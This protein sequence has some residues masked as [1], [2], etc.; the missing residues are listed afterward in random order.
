VILCRLAPYSAVTVFILLNFVL[1]LLDTYIWYLLFS[2]A[3]GAYHG[4]IHGISAWRPWS[5]DILKLP[6][7]LYRKLVPSVVT[8]RQISVAAIWNA[9]V[10]SFFRDH[11][12]S[13]KAVQQML[14]LPG[15]GG[16]LNLPAYLSA[17]GQAELSEQPLLH[18]EAWRRIQFLSKSL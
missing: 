10:L 7:Q 4:L 18:Q 2:T 6:E 9:I 5:S 11:L 8:E 17:E 14:Y 1:F 13:V 3:L 12:I 16:E 15:R